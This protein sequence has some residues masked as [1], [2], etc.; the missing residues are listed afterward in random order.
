MLGRD[1][2]KVLCERVLQR[3]GDESAE[4]SIVVTDKSLTRFA[5]NSIHQNVAENNIA[6]TVRVFFG[7]CEGTA[8]TNRLDQDGLDE[9]VNR[10]RMNAK[11]SPENPEFPGLAGPDSYEY[12]Q[13]FD[14]ITAEFSAKERA[15][16][17]RRV[18]QIAN[19]EGFNAFGAFTTGVS[20]L[21]LSNSKGL[22][23]YN[24]STSADYQ[25]V[26]M[27]ADGPASSWA[28]TSGWRVEDIDVEYLGQEA[29]KKTEDGANPQMIEPGEYPVIL[30]P[31]ATQDMLL[32]LN[33]VGMGANTLQ[34]GRSWMNN[35]IGKK[36]FSPTVNI[37]DDAFDPSGI[38]IPFDYEG[39]PKQR[40][41]IVKG[42]VV[43]GPVYDRTTALKDGVKST[44]HGMPPEFNIYSPMAANLFMAP[45]ESSV[46]EM[47]S[48]T[49]KGL[50]ITR[51]W[52]TRPVHPADCVIT[53]MTR[54]GVFWIE[55]GRIKFPVKNLRF[56]QSYIEAL[57]K[58]EAISQETRLLT[59]MGFITCSVPALKLAGFN[60][61]GSTV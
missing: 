28:Q 35:R 20:E 38:P 46:N 51:F 58:V 2:I 8:S 45:G 41:D 42:G 61:T 59:T 50:Y 5:N 19:T 36:V 56:T 10:A 9:L 44:G 1:A 34:E 7:S 57:G 27:E 39:T 11:N 54:D 55:N 48:N 13:A 47:I 49:E 25:T 30:E 53:G 31:Y 22:F 32:M 60:F 40:V 29:V 33:R 6:V 21:A 43:I 14:E 37:R 12:V 52:Y 4:V 17:I 15:E 26:V 18:C 24:V 23:S 16:A 3:A